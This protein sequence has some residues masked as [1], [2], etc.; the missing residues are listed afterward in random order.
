MNRWYYDRLGHSWHVIAL[1]RQPPNVNDGKFIWLNIGAL[2]LE[3]D[4]YH[5][6]GLPCFGIFCGNHAK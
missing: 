5:H 4:C 3:K 1:N 2:N 6:F